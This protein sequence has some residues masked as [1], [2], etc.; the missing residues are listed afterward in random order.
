MSDEQAVKDAPRAEGEEGDV[1]AIPSAVQEV[2][3]KVRL[4]QEEE[5]GVL[6]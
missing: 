1:L 2:Q 6:E 5:G 3:T 4:G